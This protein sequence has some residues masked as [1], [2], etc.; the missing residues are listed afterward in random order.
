[1]TIVYPYNQRTEIE[2]RETRKVAECY[3]SVV[4]ERTETSTG[5]KGDERFAALNVRQLLPIVSLE[6]VL[7]WEIS[8]CGLNGHSLL[9]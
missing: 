4:A 1:M 5:F 3:G 7:L 9:H 2:R 8:R 6:P